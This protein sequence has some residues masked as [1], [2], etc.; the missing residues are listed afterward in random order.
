MEM[1]LLKALGVGLT[2]YDRGNFRS[3][4]ALGR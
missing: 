2:P 4:D 3:R 1:G